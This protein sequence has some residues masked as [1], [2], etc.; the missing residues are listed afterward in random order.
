MNIIGEKKE[1]EWLPYLKNDVLS[2]SFYYAR[3]TMG[4]EILTQFGNKNRLTL[5]SLANKF[6]YSLKDENDEDI[7]TFTDPF[8]R[9]FVRKSI[10]RGRCSALNQY[11]RST[12]SDQVFNIMS[13]EL[14]V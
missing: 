5:P 6:S 1:K 2:N 3:Y 14:N 13:Q 10:K 11:Y 12:I 8:M 4:W 7:C 9:H